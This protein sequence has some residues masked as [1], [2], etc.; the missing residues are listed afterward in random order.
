MAKDHRNPSIQGIS[1]V[2]EKSVSN[3]SFSE[4]FHS[5]VHIIHRY[6]LNLC[7]NFMFCCKIYHL[8]RLQLHSS[9]ATL[10]SYPSCS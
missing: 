1:N 6:N 5:S 3:I 8:L 7:C 9:N 2:D 10:P 4:T